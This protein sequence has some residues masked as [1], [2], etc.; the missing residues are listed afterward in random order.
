VADSPIDLVCDF[1]AAWSRL[2]VEELMGYFT[3]DAT[4][5]NMPGPPA[6]GVDAIRRT[7]DGFV[8]GWDQTDWEIVSIA[9]S[10]N[11]VLVERMDRTDAGAKHVEL[12]V[13]GVFE[14]EDGKIRAW[15]D[16]FD[17]A[18]YA[19]AMSQT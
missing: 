14:I 17:L 16:Y 4:Y 15:R 10:D 11:T 18:T 2:D 13:V 19:R 1:C 8:R 3:E 6:R 12:P 5:H 9:A 7:I